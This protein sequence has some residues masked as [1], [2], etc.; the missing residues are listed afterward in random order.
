MHESVLLEEVLRSFEGLSLKIFIDGTIGAGGHA[1][2]ILTQHPEIERFIGF[3]QDPYALNIA[4]NKLEKNWGNKIT[5]IH[6]NFVNFDQHL[7]R[8]G[9]QGFDGMLLDLG[10]SSMQLDIAERGFSF[11]KE[12]PL[13]M[14]MDPTA[15]LTAAEIVNTWTERELG[16]LFRDSGEEKEW[17]RAARAIV[18]AREQKPITTTLEL[19]NVLYPVL[20]HSKKTI[21]PLTLIFQALRICVNQELEKL[22]HVLPKAI[23]LLNP[24]GRLAVISF[25]SLEDR[26]VK[27]VFRYAG[28]DKESTSGISGVF[29]DKEPLVFPITKK[30]L[31]AGDEEINRNPRSRSA[32]LRVVEK[33]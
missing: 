13:D 4:Q 27:N 14:R 19:A 12:G 28:D 26:V 10:V 18:R 9:I 33:L 6:S 8:L 20:R 21:N 31:E 15:A 32:K 22:E 7:I 2:A 17:R 23:N 29:A 1:S 5:L 3:D 24:G 30:P 11:S 25:H 16:L